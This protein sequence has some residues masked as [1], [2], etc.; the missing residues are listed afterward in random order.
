MFL[1]LLHDFIGP[2]KEDGGAEESHMDEDLPF[3]VFGIFIRNV[4]E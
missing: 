2:G 3:D 4:D 1:V